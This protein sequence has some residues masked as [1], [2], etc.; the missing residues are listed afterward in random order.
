MKASAREKR[1]LEI[2]QAAFKVFTRNGFHEAKIEEIAKKAGIGKGTIYE[3][4]DSKKDLFQQMIIYIIE[5]YIQGAEEIS[6]KENTVRE[7]LIAFAAYHGKFLQYH[8]DMTETTVTKLDMLSGNM[9]Q[10]VREEQSKV[11]NFVLK[12][13]KEGMGNGELREDLNSEIAAIAI[14]GAINQSYTRQIYF[15]KM[16]AEDI[17]PT[18]AIDMIFKGLSKE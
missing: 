15:G 3:Y 12:I 17:D 13:I 16:R 9:K 8:I 10:W 5:R 4:F 1:E 6:V 14:I 7:K 2:M 11:H 18:P